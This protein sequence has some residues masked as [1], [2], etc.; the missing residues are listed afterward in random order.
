[1][2]T[3]SLADSRRVGAGR[4]PLPGRVHDLRGDGC[5]KAQCPERTP[6][7]PPFVR[8]R[9][10]F[11]YPGYWPYVR[12][13]IER[14][15][16]DTAGFLAR[17]GH[18][19]HVI[20]STPGRPRIG[21]DGAVKVTYVRQFSHPLV[22]RYRPRL[23][24]LAFAA[25]ASRVL[26]GERADVAHLWNYSL[27]W[28]PVIRRWLDLPYLFQVGLRG[29]RLRGG[30]SRRLADRLMTMDIRGANRLVALTPGGAADVEAQFGVH[31]GV[32][33]PPVDMAFFRPVTTRTERPEVLFTSD[34]SDP[35]KG[36]RLLLRAWNTVHSRCPQAVLVLAGP[37]GLSGNGQHPHG[38]IG[39]AVREL[40]GPGATDTVEVRG[41]G[42][43][44]ELPGWYSRASVTVLPSLGEAFGMVLTESLAC[45]TPVVASSLEGPGEIVTNPDIGRTVDL[46]A[47]HAFESDERAS[48]LAD[49]I[50]ATIE[51]AGAPGAVGRCREW[52]S[53][54]SLDR[55]GLDEERLLEAIIEEHR[56]R[57]RASA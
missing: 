50:L 27:P 57:R 17:R 28:A 46:S 43:L 37:H 53:R 21:Y 33:P 47:P 38:S 44:E 54:W 25:E 39:L 40:V 34:L 14:C 56:G 31:C 51:L 48:Q 3:A 35:L 6:A 8:M 20:T 45:G 15:I 10:A 41:P 7:S 4:A 30:R 22:Y 5:R 1:V 52:A 24:H 18:E 2:E 55:V 29:S 12:R 42:S 9:I 26:A 49:A 19:V 32:L 13:G 23:R 16:H 11:P 36:G